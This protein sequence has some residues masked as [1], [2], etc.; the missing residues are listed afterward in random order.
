MRNWNS[1]KDDLMLLTKI[2]KFDSAHN[3]VRYHGKCEKLHGHTYRMDITV[4]GIP[5]DEGMI[6]D[7]SLLKNIV[8]K[9]VISQLDHAYLND[10][11]EQPSAENISIW[12]WNKLKN[13]LNLENYKL[14]EVKIFETETSFITYRG[15]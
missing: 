15:I 4:E 2:F 8:K 13:P 1:E 3:L 11:I 12:V 5:D 6:I 14:Y 10:F 9:L 7:F